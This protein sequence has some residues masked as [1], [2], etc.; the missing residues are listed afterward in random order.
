MENVGAMPDGA[1]RAGRAG[2]FAARR[3]LRPPCAYLIASQGLRKI[4]FASLSE[5][6]GPH[7]MQRGCGHPSHARVATIWPASGEMV[8]SS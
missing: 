7:W 4:A 5:A 8:A 1:M 6:K 3:P 2:D